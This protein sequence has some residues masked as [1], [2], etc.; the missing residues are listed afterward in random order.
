MTNTG[1]S[2]EE[3]TFNRGA[4]GE[5]L[6]VYAIE[7][8]GTVLVDSDA[9][10][11]Y[12]ELTTQNF[13]DPLIEK[14]AKHFDAKLWTGNGGT[15]LVGGGI[16]YSDY[17]TGDIDSSFPAYRAFRNDTASVGV[18]TAT[19]SGAT[20]V[21]QPPSPIAFTNS[22]KIWLPVM[23]HLVALALRLPMQEVQP[24]LQVQLLQAQ[25]KLLLI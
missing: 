5:Y 11:G 21:W 18:R 13:D 19:A 9:D 10:T 16:R 15:Q 2:V 3:I 17:V 23:V 12:K 22:F 1:T 14:P 20:I 24:T 25:P 7:V 6:D 8:N 4:A